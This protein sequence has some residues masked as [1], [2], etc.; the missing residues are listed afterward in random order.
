MLGH[1]RI[2]DQ[3]ATVAVETPAE[4]FDGARVSAQGDLRRADIT[5]SVSEKDRQSMLE[6]KDE[7]VFHTHR[8]PTFGFEGSYREADHVV[9]GVLTLHGVSNPCV[10][11]VRLQRP[12]KAGGRFFV[13]GGLDL[14]LR[15]FGIKPYKALFGGI[16]VKP[17]VR[18]T[19]SLEISRE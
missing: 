8:F 4:E 5:G 10:L 9:A 12:E 7:E 16:K 11:P 13:E 3:P 19:Y 1:D 18:V 14:D 2:F 17:I 15:S 6:K